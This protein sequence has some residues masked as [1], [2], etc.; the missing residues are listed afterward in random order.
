MDHRNVYKLGEQ[1]APR[2]LRIKKG[3]ILAILA[4][5]FFVMVLL[6]WL[7]FA[8]MGWFFNHSASLVENGQTGVGTLLQGG[9]RAI[10]ESGLLIPQL[11]QEVNRL[12][13]LAEDPAAILDKIEPQALAGQLG[14]V[15]NTLAGKPLADLPQQ[16][17]SGVELVPVTRFPGLIRS[18]FAAQSDS[19]TAEYIGSADFNSVLDHYAEGFNKAGYQH[20]IVSAS[21]SVEVHRYYRLIEA[22]GKRE[23]VQISVSR[24]ADKLVKVSL[25][26]TG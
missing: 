9:V 10:N 22:T 19:V 2:L 21:D 6:V 15:V 12:A 4:S 16:D 14:S 5:A 23:T 18:A 24:Y 8:V 1:I 26:K 13:A 20:E 3:T 25:R 17:V 11:Q 7:F